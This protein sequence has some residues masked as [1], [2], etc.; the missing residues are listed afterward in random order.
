[1]CNLFVCRGALDGLYAEFRKLSAS[2]FI[3]GEPRRRFVITTLWFAFSLLIAIFT[4]NIGVV[5]EL[6][7]SLA[8]ANVFIFP[9]LCLIAITKRPDQKLSTTKRIFFYAFAVTLIIVGM[10]IFSIVLYQ[11]VIDFQTSAESITHEV[12]CK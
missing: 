12:L 8:S 10:T 6:L 2:E 7:G 5:I 4:P 3:E 9:S 11:V 1:M